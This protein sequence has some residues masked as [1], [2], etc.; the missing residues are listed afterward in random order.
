MSLIGEITVF[1]C[2]VIV[3]VVAIARLLRWDKEYVERDYRKREKEKDA[4]F[5]W[6]STA[7]MEQLHRAVDVAIKNDDLD[8]S[9]G[10]HAEIESRCWEMESRNKEQEDYERSNEKAQDRINLGKA[11]AREVVKELKRNQD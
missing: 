7:T 1:S 3:A 4:L 10:I 5:K 8:R 9:E 11:I 2:I 6:A